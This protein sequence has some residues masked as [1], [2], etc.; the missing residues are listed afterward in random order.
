MGSNADVCYLLVN[1]YY[2]VDKIRELINSR[3]CILT[4][5]LTIINNSHKLFDTENDL[6]KSI[7]SSVEYIYLFKN[8]KW[9]MNNI[10]Q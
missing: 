5:L 4:T 6:L 1:F 2:T 3:E 10:E 8:G 9:Y 7:N